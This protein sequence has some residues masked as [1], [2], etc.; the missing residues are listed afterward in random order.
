VGNLKAAQIY[1][2]HLPPNYPRPSSVDS[3]ALEKFIRAKYQF[4]KFY[5][6]IPNAN[7]RRVSVERRSAENETVKDTSTPSPRKVIRKQPPNKNDVPS[8]V[9]A[10]EH[11]QTP[12]QTVFHTPTSNIN[13]FGVNS[14]SSHSAQ[15]GLFGSLE[16]TKTP[17]SN[18]SLFQVPQNENKACSSAVK[19]E[20]LGLFDQ[21]TTPSFHFGQPQP[22]V[23]RG[24]GQ[25]FGGMSLGVPTQQYP[26]QQ[27]QFL[28]FPQFQQQ[29]QQQFQ[30]QQLYQQ[31]LQIQQQLQQQQFQQQQHDYELLSKIQSKSQEN[32][33]VN[34]NLSH[35]ISA[36]LF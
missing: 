28:Q 11:L 34:N 26:Q 31:Q 29:Q 12:V 30:Q 10:P 2:G 13:L 15:P 22:Q 27:A 19:N 21:P 9:K 36:V 33:M 25:L 8:H 5:S 18:P 14:V 24:L 23:Q 17:N 16:V 1:E 20:I 3:V 4:K 32:Q 6:E 35:P 7:V